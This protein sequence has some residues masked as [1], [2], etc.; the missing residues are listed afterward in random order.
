MDHLFKKVGAVIMTSLFDTTA[1]GES[2]MHLGHIMMERSGLVVAFSNY[3]V[4]NCCCGSLIVI[5]ARF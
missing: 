4:L 1:H 5:E 2:N 3:V